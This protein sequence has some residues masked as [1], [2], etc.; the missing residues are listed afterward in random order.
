MAGQRWR[1]RFGV[2]RTVLRVVAAVAALALPVSA[3]A[4][5]LQP[6][7][8]V[9]PAATADR[10]VVEKAARRLHLYAGGRL[11]GSYAVALGG[12]PQ[13]PKV[14]EGDERTPEGRYR[15]SGR[16]AQS[17]YYRALRISYPSAGDRARAAAADVP[18]GG[19][20]MI[21]GLPNGLGWLG[22]LHRLSD[23]TAGCIAVTDTEMDEIWH[24]VPDGTPIEIRP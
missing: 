17:R 14:R 19:D 18:P 3:V 12:A 4:F 1:Q 7:P 11:I 23:W 15:I 5:Q 13:G 22:G 10:V 24:A 16:N 20:I 6:E 2:M 9:L 21:H 8:H